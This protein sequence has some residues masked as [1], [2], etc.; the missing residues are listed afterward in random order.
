MAGDFGAPD[1]ET[2]PPAW[3]A[4]R[5]NGG[6]GRWPLSTF[7]QVPPGPLR[8]ELIAAQSIARVVRSGRGEL[9]LSERA[10]ERRPGV[11]RRTVKN[12][13]D[14]LT[15]PTLR[16]AVRLLFAVNAMLVPSPKSLDA[17]RRAELRRDQEAAGEA[18]R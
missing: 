13:E 16:S 6:D 11:A 14:G 3:W 18:G 12:V 5:A 2:H 8:D 4:D 7:P 17:R 9:G 10:L 15:V 1:G